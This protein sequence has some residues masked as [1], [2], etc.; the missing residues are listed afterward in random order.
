MHSAGSTA[1][2]GPLGSGS[3]GLGNLNGGGGGTLR[4]VGDNALGHLA[5]LSINDQDVRPRGLEGRAGQPLNSGG[6][7]ALG[8]AGD[9]Q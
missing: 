3:E 1:S 7:P 2:D 9:K 8:F 6:L 4:G 5:G